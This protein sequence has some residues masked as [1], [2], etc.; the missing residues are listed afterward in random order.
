M[1]SFGALS[2][3]LAEEGLVEA[4]GAATP[5]WA[6][7]ASTAP[8]FRRYRW[9]MVLQTR[10]DFYESELTEEKSP[11]ALLSAYGAHGV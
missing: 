2:N 10:K 11:F 3:A 4:K 5:V 8:S 9:F 1:V 6:R 7:E